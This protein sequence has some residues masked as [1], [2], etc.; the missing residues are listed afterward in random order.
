MTVADR[1]AL[2]IRKF[3]RLAG[4]EPKFN[5]ER[6]VIFVGNSFDDI[7]SCEECGSQSCGCDKRNL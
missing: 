1:K 6:M 5:F 4:Q 7:K 2:A 3:T